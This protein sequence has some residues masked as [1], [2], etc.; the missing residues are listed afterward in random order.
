MIKNIIAMLKFK[1]YWKNVTVPRQK[2]DNRVL[3]IY[4]I[5]NWKLIFRRKNIEKNFYPLI[6]QQPMEFVKIETA[7]KITVQQNWWHHSHVV[8]E[9]IT[10]LLVLCVFGFLLHCSHHL[11]QNWLNATKARPIAR[12]W[13]NHRL[14]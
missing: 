1:K 12:Q 11:A 13:F 14:D 9:S 6:T 5:C 10:F 4:L 7:I 2:S 3:K 8:V